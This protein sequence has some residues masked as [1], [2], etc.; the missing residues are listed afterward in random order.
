M[1]GEEGKQSQRN[2]IWQELLET[3]IMRERWLLHE[4]NCNLL[5]WVDIGTLAQRGSS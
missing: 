3:G 2:D 5:G 4:Y 1:E